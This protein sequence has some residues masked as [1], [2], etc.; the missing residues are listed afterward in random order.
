[1]WNVHRLSCNLYTR[2]VYVFITNGWSNARGE[3]GALIY[4]FRRKKC[5]FADNVGKTHWFQLWM[6]MKEES[7]WQNLIFAIKLCVLPIAI[8]SSHRMTALNMWVN[9]EHQP[10][11]CGPNPILIK[12]CVF[13]CGFGLDCP[14]S[15]TD[16][17]TNWTP[18]SIW[19]NE[20]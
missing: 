14:S 16:K 13:V 3:K 11:G 12:Q 7:E 10:A 9:S 2:R 6:G 15:Q 17:Y 1:M 4:D 18:K 19:I 5:H 20:K 8:R